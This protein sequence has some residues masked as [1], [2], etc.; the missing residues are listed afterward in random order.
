MSSAKGQGWHCKTQ[1]CC[2]LHW[3]MPSQPGSAQH[4]A[5]A[6]SSGAAAAVPAAALISHLPP[7]GHTFSHP[8]SGHL[9]HLCQQHPAARLL[10]YTAPRHCC[11]SQQQLTFPSWGTH[12]G[13][14]FSPLCLTKVPKVVT[15][16]IPML[17]GNHLLVELKHTGHTGG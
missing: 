1:L 10:I 7:P 12:L 13:T 3:E 5:P 4:P 14:A 8:S 2:H 15:C 11:L 9:L 17:K 16:G 6:R